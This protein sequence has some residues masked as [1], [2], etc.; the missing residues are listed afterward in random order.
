MYRTSGIMF[1]ID[2][3]GNHVTS[4]AYYL[5]LDTLNT[6]QHHKHYD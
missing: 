5:A 6:H 3:R 2:F 4:L 1:S